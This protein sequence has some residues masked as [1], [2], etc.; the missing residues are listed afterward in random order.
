MEAYQ[1][2]LEEGIPLSEVTFCA[3]DLETTGGSAH[4]SAI[5]EIGAVKY[6]GGERI[7]VF[8]TL[9]NPVQPIPPFITQLTGI[10]DVIVREAPRIEQVL[11]ALVEFMRDT[12][13]VAHNAQFDF[14]FVNSALIDNGWDPI[15]PPAVCTARLARRLVWPDVPN[16]KLH[17]LAQ[18]FRCAAQPSHRALDDAEACAEILHAMLGLGGRMGILTLGDL[19]NAVR[20]RSRPNFGKIRLTDHLPH[21]P[22]VYL[23]KDGQGHVLYVGKAKD[24]RSR[25]KS[26]FYGDG[27]KKVEDLL[28]EMSSVEAR[29]CASELEALVVEARL[30][31]EHEPKYNR[32]GK[33]WRRYTYLKLDTSEAWPRLKVVHDLRGGGEF[34]G[35]FA[36]SSQANLAKDALEEA[37]PIRRCTRSMGASTRF[38]PCALADLGRCLAPCAGAAS[39]ERYR[40]AVGELLRALDDPGA[41]LETLESRMMALADDGRFEEAAL[42]RDRL[43]VLAESLAKRRIDSWLTAGGRMEL[44]GG[45]GAAYTLSGAA[46]QGSG[47]DAVPNPCPRERADELQAVRSW[48]AHNRPALKHSD[49]PIA[50]PVGGGAT[51]HRI[52]TKLRALERPLE[53]AR[54][55]WRGG[56]AA[57]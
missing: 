7:G 33:T 38:S 54:R 47:N 25:V 41:L 35:P 3:V 29:P 27:R 39:R 1:A 14:S 56:R 30:I 5:T 23:F 20:S 26:Y 55:H 21:A 45:D 32:Q 2:T 51:L 53:E 46:L 50:E 18:Y 57:G 12:V 36:S 49:H 22:G 15:E 11:P 34:I 4:S 8:Q 9:V 43:R 28:S 10:D 13:F 24:L 16:V 17:T 52:R 44:R 48:I 31:R 40:D 19:H 6:R 37:F 42:R